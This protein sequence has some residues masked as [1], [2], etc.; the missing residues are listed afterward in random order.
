MLDGHLS[1]LDGARALLQMRSEAGLGDDAMFDVFV[2]IESETDHLPIGRQRR[3]W[4]DAALIAK[5]PEIVRAEERA[6]QM[7]EA[8]VKRLALRF[9]LPPP[10]T[11]EILARK[12]LER[13][14]GQECVDWA[15]GML[16][17]GHDSRSVEI[18]AGLV[19]PLSHFEVCAL[20]DR[21]LEETRPPELA[22]DDPI[23][24]YVAEVVSD[25]VYDFGAIRHAF[26]LVAALANELGYPADLQPF[27]ALDSAFE[28]LR[29][30]EHPREWP[31]AT[32]DNIEEIMVLEARRFIAKYGAPR[33][34][35]ATDM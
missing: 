25:A 21:V 20:R 3:F 27:S 7:A 6:M 23:N 28:M 26:A 22:I 18:L 14:C 17:R 1:Y 16:E 2:V 4:S 12:M 29:Y 13:R 30:Q 24:A 10:T 19:P 34:L 5:E 31:G 9:P 32:R 15:I 35:S 11:V 8:D 33:E